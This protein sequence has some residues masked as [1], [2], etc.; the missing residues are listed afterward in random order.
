MHELYINFGTSLMLQC[1]IIAYAIIAVTVTCVKLKSFGWVG[2]HH[3]NVKSE[4]FIE[5]QVIP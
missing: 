3:E 4:G 2:I 1:M 5:I